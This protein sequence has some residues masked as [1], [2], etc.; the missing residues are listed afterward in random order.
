MHQKGPYFAH[1]LIPCNLREIVG[2]FQ[3]SRYLARLVW[4]IPIF[5]RKIS[6][7]AI[8]KPKIAENLWKVKI[9][10]M[11]LLTLM[12]LLQTWFWPIFAKFEGLPWYFYSFEENNFSENHHFHQFARKMASVRSFVRENKSHENWPSGI[13]F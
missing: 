9:T 5:R 12:T 6:K 2:P 7:M 8:F 11:P 3:N 1:V 10:K 13:K 4:Q